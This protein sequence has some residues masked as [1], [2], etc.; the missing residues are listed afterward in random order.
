MHSL[1][2][3]NVLVNNE[4]TSGD[5]Y[6]LQSNLLTSVIVDPGNVCFIH[7]EYMINL[8]E[9]SPDSDTASLSHAI[10]DNQSESWQFG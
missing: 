9:K 6:E 2:Q 5:I 10:T 3:L 1:K 8:R 7:L 4:M